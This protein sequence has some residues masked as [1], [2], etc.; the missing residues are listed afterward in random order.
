M[1]S[2]TK[3]ERMKPEAPL[4]NRFAGRPMAWKLCIVSSVQ[5]KGQGADLGGL[6]QEAASD[7]RSQ[8]QTGP[9]PNVV[10]DPYEEA[11]YLCGNSTLAAGA[12]QN[13]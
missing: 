13:A 6:E 5:Q 4:A 9:R 12:G 3:L 10:R 8:H 11:P 7:R 2:S 1:A